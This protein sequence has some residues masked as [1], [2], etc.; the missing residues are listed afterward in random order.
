MVGLTVCEH[1]PMAEV[2][3]I[4]PHPSALF[5]DVADQDVRESD[6]IVDY[7]N[8]EEVAQAL[9]YLLRNVLHLDFRELWHVLLLTELH[10]ALHI[11]HIALI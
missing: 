8:R 9:K 11:Q 6:V 7:P 1:R 5:I 10:I 4:D 3:E 2:I